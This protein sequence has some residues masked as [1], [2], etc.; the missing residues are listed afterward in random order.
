MVKEVINGMMVENIMVNILMIK[1]KVMV[2][3]FGLMED[4]I[5]DIGKMGNRMAKVNIFLLMDKKKKVFGNKGKELNGLN[6]NNLLYNNYNYISNYKIEQ[7]IFNYNLKNDFNKKI[8][9]QKSK[10]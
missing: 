7:F 4:D 3:I 9:N 5:K 1:N 2:A 8:F 10:K 6:N